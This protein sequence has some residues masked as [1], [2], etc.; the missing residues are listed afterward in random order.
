MNRWTYLKCI[1]KVNDM[2]SILYVNKT[3][4]ISEYPM[5]SMMI[6]INTLKTYISKTRR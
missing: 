6:Y 1:S 4:Y 5:T 2:M 3:K